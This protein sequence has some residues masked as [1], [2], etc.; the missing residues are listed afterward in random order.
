MTEVIVTVIVGVC[1]FNLVQ[2]LRRAL[3]EDRTRDH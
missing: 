2:Q 1:I 3:E